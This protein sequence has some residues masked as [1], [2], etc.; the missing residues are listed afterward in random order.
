MKARLA[1][2]QL[3]GEA[4]IEVN[5]QRAWDLQVHNERTFRRI[6]SQGSLGAGESYMEGWWDAEQLD[7]LFHR[8]LRARLEGRFRFSPGTLLTMAR[9][10]AINY[11]RRRPFQIGKDHYD[12]G[13]ELF[14][15]MLDARMT[16]TCGYWKNAKTLDQAQEAKLDLVCRKLGVREGDCILDIGSGWGSFINYAAEK[17][18]ARCVG[19]TVS[20]EQAEFANANRYGPQVETR[21]MDYREVTGQFDHVVSLGMFEHVGRKNYRT[22]MKKVR[23]VLSDD[24]LF[25]LHTIGKNQ[26]GVSTDAWI[27]K[28]IFPNSMI[29][30]YRQIANAASR[31]FVLEDWHNFGADYDHTLMHW[32]RNFDSRWEELKDRYDQRFYRM[33]KYYLLTSAGSFRARR[34]SLWQIVFSKHGLAGGYRRVG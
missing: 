22:F 28:Y 2:T 19:L 13:N 7:E 1:L 10:L 9:G 3:L 8:L 32:W 31:L 29:P 23:S 30:S 27:S 21:L 15:L 17:Y 34:N 12:V 18:G 25:L 33:W 26:S 24:G 6:M 11:A 14:R 20:R 16:Y 5:G 4:D